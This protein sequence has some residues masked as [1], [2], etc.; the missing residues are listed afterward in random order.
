[1]SALGRSGLDDRS[2]LVHSFVRKH[3]SA[4]KNPW[5]LPAREQNAQSCDWLHVLKPLSPELLNSLAQKSKTAPLPFPAK[6][7][8]MN[9]SLYIGSLAFASHQ[10]LKRLQK[11]I[12]SVPKAT[13]AQHGL[14]S[15]DEPEEEEEDE[16]GEYM[17]EETDSNAWRDCPQPHY[18]F[19]DIPIPL[20]L[21]SDIP[22]SMTCP[23]KLSTNLG[24]NTGLRQFSNNTSVSWD[25]DFCVDQPHSQ[26]H[27]PAWMGLCIWLVLGSYIA[28]AL[29]WIA[30]CG[31]RNDTVGAEPSPEMVPETTPET[32]VPET[33]ST[34]EPEVPTGQTKGK[35]VYLSG[36]S[37]PESEEV[38]QRTLDEYGA[39]RTSYF[40]WFPYSH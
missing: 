27:L 22:I 35:L 9:L 29:L 38:Y 7:L 36:N 4:R 40:L 21:H 14:N 6:V 20:T 31:R 18:T 33:T 11:H 12:F 2:Y 17:C 3:N 8:F 19:N 32:E 30:F 34:F 26:E 5:L 28:M 13:S 10:T 1:M 24:T 39:I 16:E 25:I 23:L 15:S 37:L